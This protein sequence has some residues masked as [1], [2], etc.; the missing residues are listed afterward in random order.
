MS[1]DIY[2]GRNNNY[3]F[4]LMGQLAP[5]LVLSGYFGNPWAPLGTIPAWIIEG[6]LPDL[7]VGCNFRNSSTLK[8]LAYHEI[9]HASHFENAGPIFWI[10]LIAAEVAADGHGTAASVDAGVMSIAESWAEYFSYVCSEAKYGGAYDVVERLKNESVNHIPIGYYHDLVDYLVDEKN[11][12]DYWGTC[13]NITDN[14]AGFNNAQMYS[15]L[16]GT[17][18]SPAIFTNRLIASFLPTTSNTK[19]QVDALFLSY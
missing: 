4:A 8:S 2:I 19:S 12:C 6:L 5:G 7:Y 13:G 14:V 1:L 10:R 18:T 3:G 17:C 11:A 16:T 15:L 9:A